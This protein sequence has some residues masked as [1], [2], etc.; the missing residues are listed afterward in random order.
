MYV[1]L[2]M[3]HSNLIERF[4][5]FNMVM[6]FFADVCIGSLF[7]LSRKMIFTYDFRR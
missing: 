3:S 7:L 1:L 4:S 6:W 5:T 2:E